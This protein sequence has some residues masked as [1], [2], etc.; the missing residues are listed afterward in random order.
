VLIRQDGRRRRRRAASAAAELVGY[1]ILAELLALALE[2]AV[3][4]F[5]EKHSWRRGSGGLLLVALFLALAVL[6][7]GLAAVLARETTR[8]VSE[9]PSYVDKINAFTLDHFDTTVFK[10]APPPFGPG[11]GRLGRVGS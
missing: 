8:V 4:W 5:H 1:L 3:I 7:V 6:V 11:R 9:L 10:V 2:P